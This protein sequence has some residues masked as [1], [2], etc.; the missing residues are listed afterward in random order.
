MHGCSLKPSAALLTA[1]LT[2]AC[3]SAL[4]EPVL[5]VDTIVVSGSRSA[6][7]LLSLPS[8]I[9]VVQPD[10]TITADNV[11]DMLKDVGSV[12]LVSDGTPGVKR[13]SIRGESASRTLLL[14]DGERIDDSKTK[15][16]APLLVNPF[17][18]DRIEILRGPSSVLYGS[19]AMGGIVNVIS[20]QAS[21]EPFSAEGGMAYIGSGSGFSEYLNLSGTVNKFSYVLGG[22]NTDMGD[23]YLANHDR[24]G[25]TSYYS[26]G[27]NADLKYAFTDEAS[28]TF[29]SEYF[30]VNARTATSTEDFD[31]RDFKAHIPKWERVKNSLGLE[32]NDI[33]EYLARVSASFYL[34]QNE[35]DFNS[36]VTSS[37]PF[38]EVN[39]DQDTYGGNLQL[40]FA[41]S[42]MFYLTAGYDGRVDELSSDSSAEIGSMRI[43]YSDDDYKQTTHAV[44]GLLESY[45]TDRLTLSTG[46][47]WNYVQTDPG[48][49][50]NPMFGP[51]DADSF[52]NTHVVGSAGLVYRAFDSGAFRFNWSQGFRVPNIQELYLTTFTGEIQQGNP[53]LDPETSDNFELGFRY[54]GGSFI[55]DFALFYTKADNYI[56]T[57]ELAGMPMPMRYFTYRNIAEAVSYGAEVSLSYSFDYVTP[58]ADFTLMEREY[59][60]GRETSKNTGT[61]KFKGRAGLKYQDHFLSYPYYADVYARFATQSRNDNLEGTSYFDNTRFGG[62]ITLNLMAGMSFGD[63][64]QYQIYAGVENILDKDYQTTE[65]MKEPGRFFTAGFSAAF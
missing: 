11:P 35:K 40:E 16:G 31:Y 27:V 54:E 44:Y 23:L 36:S 38:I 15:S 49:C 2:A 58:Y 22:F 21:P 62:Y 25:N 1:A 41:L 61:P 46:V 24:I 39:N 4:A 55:G 18:I 42:E 28:I 3:G 51:D 63:E 56:E 53:D 57:Y 30:D 6:E 12:N 8:S 19:D 5:T 33:N 14:V 13:I 45:L 48:T 10:R 43:A 59:D 9:S 26:Q 37:G 60:T 50:S 47:R 52:T 7:D 29:K 32:L 17:F 65:L 64:Q 34:Q 20:K